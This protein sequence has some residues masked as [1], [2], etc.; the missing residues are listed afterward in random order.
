MKKLSKREMD[1]LSK[2]TRDRVAQ[3]MGS[4]LQLVDDEEQ[5]VFLLLV[6]AVFCAH[7]AAHEMH[8]A[9]QEGLAECWARVNILIAEAMCPHIKEAVELFVKRKVVQ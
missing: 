5:R 9:R 8:D 2:V 1:D 3:A 6:G 4:V 7:E